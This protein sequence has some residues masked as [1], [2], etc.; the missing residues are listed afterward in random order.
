MSSQRCSQTEQTNPPTLECWLVGGGTALLAAAVHL[1]REANVSGRHI[2]IIEIHSH[3][4]HEVTNYGNPKSGY[5]VHAGLQPS[6]H[7]PCTKHF[8]SL[9]PHPCEPAKTLLDVSESSK[10]VAWNKQTWTR[11]LKQS[12][13]GP[14]RMDANRMHMRLKDQIDL[15]TFLL[16]SENG[17]GDR[18]I[19]QCFDP[20]FFD[21]TFWVLWSTTFAIQSQHSA[22]EFQRHLSKYLDKLEHLSGPHIMDQMQ[23]MFRDSVLVPTIDFLKRSGVTFEK[24]GNVEIFTDHGKR[25]LVASRIN[26]LAEHGTSVT[27]SVRP[28]DIVIASLGPSSSPSVLGSHHRSPASELR[29]ADGENGDAWALW[30]QLASENQQFGNPANFNSRLS[31]SKLVTFTI[32]LRSPVFIELYTRLT[33][34]EPGAGTFTTVADCAWHLTINVPRQPVFPDQPQNIQVIWGYGVSPERNGD[35]ISKPMYACSGEE[36]MAELLAH[37]QFPAAAILPT[38]TLI[39]CIMPYATSSLLTRR[40]GDRPSIIPN[41]VGNMALVGQFVDI[42][43]DTTFSM[44]YN[45]RSA[46]IAVYELMGLDLKPPAPSRS[47]FMRIFDLLK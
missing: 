34:N 4:G 27:I 18:S 1:I 46:Q 44:D 10:R 33:N 25:G 29:V 28:T 41:N 19:R 38:T 32:T 6:F 37:L 47:H 15:A 8:L 26:L 45:I 31:E 39:P 24:H 3:S 2:H 23:Y 12:Q 35:Y 9:V 43:N 7:E 36:I 16:E 40:P 30:N 21:S 14:A 5:T 17:L 11:L 22:A 20:E 13:F 42:P